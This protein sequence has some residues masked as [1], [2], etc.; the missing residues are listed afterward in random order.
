MLKHRLSKFCST[1]AIMLCVLFSGS[2]IQS[3][4]DVF[5]DY[6]YDD[7]RPK[8]LGSSIYDFLKG[9]HNGESYNYYV[10]LIDSLDYAD[11]LART[12]SKT[13]FVANDSAFEEFFK[14]NRWGVERFEDLTK[15]QMKI[16]LYSAMLD[17]TLQHDMLSSTGSTAGSEGT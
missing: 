6:K 5:D 2:F 10:A 11:V 14:N 13:L 15:A 12:G 16:L 7:E 4:T 8:W 3:C 9:K 1:V 17:N